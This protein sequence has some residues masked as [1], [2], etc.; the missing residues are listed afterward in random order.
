MHQIL[1]I[2]G[3]VIKP[4]RRNILQRRAKTND[5]S[6]YWVYRLQTAMVLW[7]R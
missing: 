6:G 2:L 3:Y 4:Q 1:F 7:S 5:T